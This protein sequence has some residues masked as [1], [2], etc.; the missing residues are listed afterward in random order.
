MSV[1]GL[2]LGLRG[3]CVLQHAGLAIT[4][5]E[6]LHLSREA[7]GQGDTGRGGLRRARD[8]MDPNPICLIYDSRMCS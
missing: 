2:V 7:C 5:S 3:N 1:S 8:G 6:A 4:H